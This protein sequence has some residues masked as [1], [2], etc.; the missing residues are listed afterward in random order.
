[1]ETAKNNRWLCPESI[2][3]ITAILL[4]TLFSCCSWIYPTNPWDDANV[5]MTIGKSMK[6]GM[7]LY[8]D[9]FDHKGTC[10]HLIHQLASYV[11][12][13][14]F[15]G[16]YILEIVCLWGFLVCSYRIMRL[17]SENSITLPLTIL[18][19][20]LFITSDF[21]SYGDSV[22]EFSLPIL[23]YS[24]YLI[25]RF[26]KTGRPPKAWHSILM[27]V[28]I[29]MIFWMKYTILVFY[30]G[31]L[32]GLLCICY[33]NKQ[34]SILYKILL[35]VFV[36]LL[37]VTA[38]IVAYHIYHGTLAEMYDAYFYANI[39]LYHDSNS[40]G[41]P[42]G[43]AFK[44]LKLALCVVLV[45]PVALAKVRWEIKLTVALAY[46][47][48]L[49]SYTFMKAHIYYFVPLFVFSPLIIYLFRNH[50]ATWRTYL[51]FVLVATASI[52]INFNIVTLLTGK[53]PCTIT[54]YAQIINS[55]TS[56]N[57]KVLTFSSHDTGIY[58]LTNQLPPNKHF[59]MPNIK[60][61]EIKVEQANTLAKGDIK[62]LIRKTDDNPGE[63]QLYYNA[64]IPKDYELILQK[65]EPYRYRFITSPMMHLWSLGYTQRWLKHIM[66][67]CQEYQTFYL[68]RKITTHDD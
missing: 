13:Y 49:L 4:V 22:E 35:Q 15:K 30:V 5:F 36:G 51:C 41:E 61:P 1:M 28:G 47:S 64:E 46:L 52:S 3:L 60:I 34:L 6:H 67:P 44:L 55:D 9:V 31:A 11:S 23:S 59:Y 40:N 2:L 14:S 57:K 56:S 54:E 37:I 43:V 7:K 17:F 27:G 8:L 50:K 18:A 10:L 45:A 33:R 19:G 58:V 20:T 48:L 32:M 66:A 53:F 65:R 62:Y 39:F 25:L 21:F 24:L 68:Y 38:F 42:A 12:E 29:G 26:L 63:I 16:I